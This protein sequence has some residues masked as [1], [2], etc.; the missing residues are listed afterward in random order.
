MFSKGNAPILEQLESVTGKQESA[1]W[2]NKNPPSH[3]KICLTSC[4]PVAFV[5]E[6]ENLTAISKLVQESG[7]E[8]G[9]AR[10][11][12]PALEFLVG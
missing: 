4:K 12:C 8:D 2:A 10:D 7:G 5:G 3:Q 9:I 6:I 11:F 1:G